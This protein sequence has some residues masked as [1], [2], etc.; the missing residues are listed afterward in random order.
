M[1]QERSATGLTQ[2]ADGVRLEV[3]VVPGASR[4]RVVGRLGGRLKLAVTAAPEDGKANKAVCELLAKVFGVARRDVQIVA[5]QT[6]ALKMV[7][8]IGIK[9]KDTEAVVGSGD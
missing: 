2:M 9:M 5:G 4:T 6:Q 3:K 8:V 7:E 1:S